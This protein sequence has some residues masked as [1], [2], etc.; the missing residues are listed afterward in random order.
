VQAAQGSRAGLANGIELR[1]DE[2]AGRRIGIT[3]GK[4]ALARALRYA[5]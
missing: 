5:P 2:T 4:R 3:V 1:A